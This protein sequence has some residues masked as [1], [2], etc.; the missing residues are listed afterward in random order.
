MNPSRLLDDITWWSFQFTVGRGDVYVGVGG[1]FS[2]GNF[3]F[4]KLKPPIYI[5]IDLYMEKQSICDYN[6]CK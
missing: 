1:D 3:F 6:V 4:K 2:S 5:H